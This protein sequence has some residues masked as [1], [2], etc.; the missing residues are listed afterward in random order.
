MYRIKHKE[1]VSLRAH[2]TTPKIL[3][4]PV[5]MTTVFLMVTKTSLTSLFS[6]TVNLITIHSKIWA[7]HFLYGSNRNIEVEAYISAADAIGYVILLK[8]IFDSFQQ[9]FDNCISLI[10]S[11]LYRKIFFMK[12]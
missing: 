6:L 3:L 1:C 7:K 5:H 11:F 4:K 8:Y 2:S 10:I 9:P 12:D